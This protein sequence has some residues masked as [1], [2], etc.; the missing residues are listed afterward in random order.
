MNNLEPTNQTKLF[1]LNRFINELIDLYNNKILPNQILLSGPKG[2]AKST[3]AYHF[4]NYVLSKDEQYKYDINN[5]EI[6]LKNR[7][8]KTTL[9]RSNPNLTIIDVN[10][11][12]KNID[13]NQIR[14]VITTLNKSSFNNKPRFV[15]IDNIELLNKNSVNALLKVL[16]EPT[17]NVHFIL[18]NNNKKILPTLLSRCINFKIFLTRNEK[19]NVANKLLDGKLNQTINP[20]LINYYLT[21]GSIYNLA[22]FGEKNKY[23]LSN[24]DLKLFLKTIIKDN[25]YKKD[26]FIKYYIFDF[27]ESYLRKINFALSSKFHNKYSNFLKRISDTKKFNLDEES[28]FMEFEDEIL[29]G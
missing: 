28:L 17:N 23:N 9:N 20:D 4:I 27:I 3:L 21:A 18:I 5:F 7:S 24:F 14:E 11:D 22:K 12:K 16:E 10:P 15:L 6:N 2:L 26:Y 25:H 8:Y 19:L 29:D 13:I 1:G